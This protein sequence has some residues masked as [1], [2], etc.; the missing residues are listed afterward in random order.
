MMDQRWDKTKLA[1][2]THFKK[3][4]SAVIFIIDVN[5]FSISLSINTSI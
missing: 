4:T 5:K 2:L 1:G 3:E